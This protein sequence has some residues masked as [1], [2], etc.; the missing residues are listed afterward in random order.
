MPAQGEKWHM[1][2]QEGRRSDGQHHLRPVKHSFTFTSSSDE[3][4]GRF[5]QYGQLNGVWTGFQA[6]LALK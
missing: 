1:R 5:D 4:D 2:G 3:E 6:V